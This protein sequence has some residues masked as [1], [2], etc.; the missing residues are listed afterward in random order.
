MS[1]SSHDPPIFFEQLAAKDNEIMIL[2]NK[3]EWYKNIVDNVIPQESK[4]TVT[5]SGQGEDEGNGE[6]VQ[7]PKP[8]QKE[9]HKRRVSGKRSALDAFYREHKNDE[10]I[11]KGATDIINT[12]Q[13]LKSCKATVK[14]CLTNEKYKEDE[15]GG[16][17]DEEVN[18]EN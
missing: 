17:G 18:D 14:R 5:K 9:K 4:I 13:V 11:E 6:V 15:E 8:K 12:Y 10:D 1:F 2:K 7:E 3:I 16:N